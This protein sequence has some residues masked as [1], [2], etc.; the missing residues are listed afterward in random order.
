MA[1][2]TS[3]QNGKKGGRPRGRKNDATLEKDKV[4]AALRQKIMRKADVLFGAQ[5]QLAQGNAYLYKTVCTGTGKSRKCKYV[6]VTDQ[7]EILDYLNGKFEDVD[8]GSGEEEGYYQITTDKPDNKA[9]DSMF[10][11][12]FGKAAQPLTGPEGGPIEIKGVSITIK[13]K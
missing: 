4:L 9:I 13:K 10:D 12:T 8:R 6:M 7:Q 3:A 2:K 11:R 1:G 5:M